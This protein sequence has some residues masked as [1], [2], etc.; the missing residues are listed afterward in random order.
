MSASAKDTFNA[1]RFKSLL[2]LAISRIQQTQKRVQAGTSYGHK[3]VSEL[4]KDSK[5]ERAR[6]RVKHIIRDDFSQEA[7]EI[8]YSYC[9][10]LLKCIGMITQTRELEAE[11]VPVVCNIIYASTRVDVPELLTVRDMLLQ[12]YGKKFYDAQVEG[13]DVLD[14]KLVQKTSVKMPERELI[15]QYLVTIADA[16]GLEYT[17]PPPPAVIPAP[18]DSDDY[19]QEE[20]EEEEEEGEEEEANNGGA[21]HSNESSDTPLEKPAA[22]NS[23]PPSYSDSLEKGGEKE[24]PAKALASRNLP[25]NY[26]D[27]ASKA[28]A[29]SPPQ[30]ASKPKE[31]AA[32]APPA[33]SSLGSVKVKKD[34]TPAPPAPAPA[35]VVKE[36]PK[37]VPKEPVGVVKS[38]DTNSAEFDDL[39]KRFAALKRK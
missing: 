23:N 3:E 33:G 27:Q 10:D 11:M 7:L 31:A 14:A 5:I 4:L 21:E 16:Y 28:S 19:E 29:T 17:P 6:L 26:K 24:G 37:E 34:A 2:R 25:A 9:D 18:L 39:A 35:P 8:I 36:P 32:A 12:R 13:G 22:G 15:E 1:V 30:P 20:E 38:K